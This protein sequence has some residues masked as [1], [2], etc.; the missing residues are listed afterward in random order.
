MEVISVNAEK[1]PN[2]LKKYAQWVAWKA[3]P[4]KD[5]KMDKI[6]IDAKTGDAGSVSDP[7]TW[8]SF[9]AAHTYYKRHLSGRGGVGFVFVGGDS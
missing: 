4:K 1:I 5:G 8:A 6:P 7:K 3:V 9:D 2:E